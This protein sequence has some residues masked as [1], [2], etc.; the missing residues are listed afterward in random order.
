MTDGTGKAIDDR[1]YGQALPVLGADDVTRDVELAL[2]QEVQNLVTWE[3]RHGAYGRRAAVA[4]A[5][6]RLRSLLSLLGRVDR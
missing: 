2:E 4:R 6:A 3:L 5:T 1:T